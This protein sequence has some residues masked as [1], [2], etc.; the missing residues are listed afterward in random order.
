MSEDEETND[1]TTDE[2]RGGTTAGEYGDQRTA[3]GDAIEEGDESTTGDGGDESATIDDGNESSAGDDGDSSATT[4]D[5]DDADPAETSTGDARV[6]ELEAELDAREA[7]IDEL[8]SR[9]RRAQADFQNYKKRQKKRQEQR[10]ASATEDLVERLLDVRDNLKRALEAEY[11]DVGALREG[12][13]LTLSEFDRVLDAE[14]VAEI[15]PEPGTGVDPQRHEVLVRVESNHP[16]G[17]IAEV[18]QPGYELGE[19]VL[20]AAQVTVSDGNGSGEDE[21]DNESVTTEKEEETTQGDSSGGD[22]GG[23]ESGGDADVT[24]SEE[25][26]R[27]NDLSDGK[28]QHQQLS[29]DEMESSETVGSENR[30]DES[31]APSED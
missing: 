10:A 11:D 23:S 28:T 18:Y 16:E 26:T 15:E 31:G 22:S 8:E 2:E 27:S 7:R 20:R 5:G 12:V 9:L 3:E 24:E 17:T 25:E 30:V 29:E 19:K 6:E 14:N 4:D 13:Q 21:S 1:R